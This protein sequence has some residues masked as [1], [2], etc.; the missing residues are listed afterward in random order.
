[1]A[2]KIIRGK[3]LPIGLDMGNSAI[4]MAQLKQ[5]E[6]NFELLAADLIEV[7]RASR[8]DLKARMAFAASALGRMMARNAFAGQK[9]VLS[10]PAEATFVHHLRIPKVPSDQIPSAAGPE[11]SGKLPF[12]PTDA[13][14][15]YLVAGDIFSDGEPKQEVIVVAVE[16]AVVDA[17]LDM[18]TR[19]KLDVIG[20]DIEPCAVVECFARVFRRAGDAA[21]T[22]LFMD[23]GAVSTQF[24]LACGQKIVFARNLAA[25]G[26]QI[27]QALAH[28]MKIPVEAA[29]ALRADL[30]T[31]K[32]NNPQAEDELYRLLEGT[33]RGISEEMTQCLRYYESIFRNQ[34]VERAIFVG[35]QAYDKRLCQAIAQRLNLPAQIGDPLVR[36]SRADG[37]GVNLGI[38]WRQPQPAWAVAVGLSLSPTVTVAA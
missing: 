31:G 23:I 6:S 26:E 8:G 1:M 38:D 27:D 10:L 34:A 24:V 33:I 35:G 12:A 25:G 3:S 30:L 37:A 17:Y 32:S 14:I 7:P 19:A 9:C 5:V 36:V 21:C 4:K 16:R 2:I 28:E 15:R 20:V 13:V 18:A 11:L 29:H 22:T